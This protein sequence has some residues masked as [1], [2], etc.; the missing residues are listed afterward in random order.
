MSPMDL[1]KL[2]RNS[3]KNYSFIQACA[4]AE[5]ALNKE[6]AEAEK[7]SEETLKSLESFAIK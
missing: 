1:V 3:E 6:L 7:P 4:A 2:V 5:Q